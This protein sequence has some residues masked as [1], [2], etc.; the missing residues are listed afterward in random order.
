MPLTATSHFHRFIPAFSA[1]K[2]PPV[3]MVLMQGSGGDEHV[4]V[5]L[6][7]DLPP[8]SLILAMNGGIPFAGQ[9]AFFHRPPDRSIDEANI[10]SHSRSRRTS[11]RAPKLNNSSGER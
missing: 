3:I 7:V 8:G 1:A 10:A 5:P 4:L 2:P 11:L 9:F 6:A